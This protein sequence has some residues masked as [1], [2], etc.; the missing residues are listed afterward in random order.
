MNLSINC[1]IH[2]KSFLLPEVLVGIKNNTTGTFEIVFCVDGCT[3]SSLQMVEYFCMNN[4]RIKTTILEAPNVFETKANNLCAKASTGEHII[5]VQDD[6]IITEMGYNERLLKP[7]KLWDDVFAV[8]GRCAHNWVINPYSVDLAQYI[9]KGI[10]ARIDG[11][12]WCDILNHTDHADKNNTNRNTFAVRNSVNR[13]PLAINLSDLQTM[14]YLDEVYAPLEY[15]EHDLMYRMRAKLGKVCG[16]FDIGWRSEPGYGGTRN[17][18]GS[19]KQWVLENNHKNTRIFY[20]KHKEALLLP[21]VIETR[22][23]S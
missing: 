23:C 17:Q 4:P 20:D 6:Q 21:G 9:E 8:T 3:D 18:D 22:N 11:Y 14:G 13:G 5:I 2:N 12:R 19:T 15:D 1:T 10:N 16:F 7:F